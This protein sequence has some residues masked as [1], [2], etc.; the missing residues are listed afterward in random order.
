M[1]LE[2]GITSTIER[3]IFSFFI[4]RTSKSFDRQ[5]A[6]GESLAA[7][8]R[9]GPKRFPGPF[10]SFFPL[11]KLILYWFVSVQKNCLFSNNLRKSSVHWQKR[12]STRQSVSSGTTDY[13]F[14]GALVYSKVLATNKQANFE[15]ITGNLGREP[16]I[17]GGLLI[18]EAARM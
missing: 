16:L 2:L 13:L 11:F 10:F 5:T 7:R 1:I 12:P 14:F 8:H 18:V 3:F 15:G 17:E 9:H 4:I 6:P